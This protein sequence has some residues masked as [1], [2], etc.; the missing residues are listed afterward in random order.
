MV[1]RLDGETSRFSAGRRFGRKSFGCDDRD[2]RQVGVE[3]PGRGPGFTA[4]VS[5]IMKTA[6]QH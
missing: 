3:A 4:K 1:K 2:E 5:D 6:Q